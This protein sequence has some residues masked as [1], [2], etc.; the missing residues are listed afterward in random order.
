MK[1]TFVILSIF[2]VLVFSIPAFSQGPPEP[3][4][5]NGGNNPDDGNTPVGGNTPIDGGLGIMLLLGAAYGGK[6]IYQ[7]KK[8]KNN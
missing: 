1:K 8:E 6:K 2:L 5:P 7:F 4:P 3:P